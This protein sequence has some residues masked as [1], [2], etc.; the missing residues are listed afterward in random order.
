MSLYTSS[1]TTP[2]LTGCKDLFHLI[3]IFAT[4]LLA[5]FELT[6]NRLPG[7]PPTGRKLEIPFTAVVN[8]RGD[9]LYHEHIAWDQL[10]A[11]I[12]LGLMPEYLPWTHPAPTGVHMGTK[13]KLEYRVPGAGR[14]TAKKMRDRNSVESNR[15]FGHSIRA[16]DSVQPAVSP[17]LA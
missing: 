8:I 2:R 16:V 15:M 17:K 3:I 6:C 7:I 4:H 5:L 10:T 9:R 12:Q 14:D 1:R 13:A 11:L